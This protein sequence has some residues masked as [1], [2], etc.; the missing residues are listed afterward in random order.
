MATVKLAASYNNNNNTC[1]NNVTARA[2][3]NSKK[4]KIIEQGQRRQ[5]CNLLRNN[6]C[7]YDLLRQQQELN[8][9]EQ[10]HRQS[11]VHDIV[12]FDEKVDKLSGIS[13]YNHK[14]CKCLSN[15]V[16][17]CDQI[18]TRIKT[19]PGVRHGDDPKC[20]SNSSGSQCHHLSNCDPIASCHQ[21]QQTNSD[22]SNHQ[23]LYHH[24]KNKKGVKRPNE[25]IDKPA[26]LIGSCQTSCGQFSSG[27]TDCNQLMANCKS[28]APLTNSSSSVAFARVR[29]RRPLD[30][31]EQ[32]FRG[33]S[34][35]DME[36]EEDN[37][38]EE[39]TSGDN[40]EFDYEPVLTKILNEKKLV[41]IYHKIGTICVPLCTYM[42]MLYEY[43]LIQSNSFSFILIYAK[44]NTNKSGKA[45]ATS[46][47]VIKFLSGI[48]LETRLMI[49]R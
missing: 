30:Q 20:F 37:D 15:N 13:G 29:D 18:M 40:E 33:H 8:N 19:V 23:N 6:N 2:S 45:L 43:S 44:P 10:P 26:V 17:S 9:C 16:Q 21:Q 28:L 49:N 4:S 27:A 34:E 25:T 14:E 35:D 42:Y 32:H 11:V 38:D 47:D 12:L 3:E 24:H 48:R 41:S 36:R 46:P 39:E 7:P 5:A 22:F 31:N 1:N